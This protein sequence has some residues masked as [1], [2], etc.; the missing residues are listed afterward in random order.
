MGIIRKKNFAILYDTGI[1][2]E[3]V[4]YSRKMMEV[5]FSG[6]F[7]YHFPTTTQLNILKIVPFMIVG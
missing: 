3:L 4:R 2:E 5:G 7:F 6:L 1:F